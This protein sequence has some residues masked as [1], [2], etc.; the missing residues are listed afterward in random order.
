MAALQT[1]GHFKEVEEDDI[2]RLRG[3]LFGITKQMQH[4][5]G[6]AKMIVSPRV[7]KLHR[8]KQ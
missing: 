7:T 4:L 2:T 3:M 1:A 6:V 8:G 5:C